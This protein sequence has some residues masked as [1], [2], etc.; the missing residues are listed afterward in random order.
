VSEEFVA[1]FQWKDMKEAIEGH[2]E[3]LKEVQTI[4]PEIMC[5]CSICRALALD[6]SWEIDLSEEVE[7][8]E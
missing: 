8:S 4:N 7:E 5:D 6:D 2:I 3:Y 1:K